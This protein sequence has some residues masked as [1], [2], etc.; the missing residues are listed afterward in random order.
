[1]TELRPFSSV[2]LAI[3]GRSLLHSNIHWR[4]RP[5]FFEVLGVFAYKKLLGRTET[6]TSRY[7]QF[8]T[9]PE[10]VEQELGSAV[11]EHRQTDMLHSYPLTTT[12]PRLS[13]L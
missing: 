11:C 9:S 1:M 13:E 12:L 6:R 8:E 3:K 10:I 5:G 4:G 7:E 2:P